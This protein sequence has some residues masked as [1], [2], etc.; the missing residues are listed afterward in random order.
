MRESVGSVW[1]VQLIILFILIFSGFLVLVINYS[2]AY[3][4]KNEMLTITEKY[5]GI[6][7]PGSDEFVNVNK[8]AVDV[9]NNYLLEK[10]YKTIGSCPKADVLNDWYGCPS[11]VD[12]KLEKVGSSGNK[13]YYYCISEVCTSADYH[14]KCYTQLRVFYKFNLPVLGDFKTFEIN[15]R[16]NTYIRS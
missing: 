8:N 1:S 4:V 3:M 6:L 12:N 13:K 11:L 10:G 15:G 14:D 16:T 9:I 7:R 2:R 5:D